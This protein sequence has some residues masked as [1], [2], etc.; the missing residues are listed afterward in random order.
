MPLRFVWLLLAVSLPLL[1]GAARATAADAPAALVHPIYGQIPDAPDHD[2]T[3]RVFT[4]AAARYH[5]GPVEVIDVLAPP[6]SHASDVIKTAARQT[7]KL[8]FADARKE[9]DAVA[10]EV[11]RTGGASL[12]TTELFDLYL[13]RAMATARADWKAPGGP[14]PPGAADE[15]RALAYQDY[16]RAATLTPDRALNPRE[17][18]PQV[19]DDFRRAADEVRAR[20]RGALVVRG[21]ADAQVS[22]DGAA[23]APVAGGVTFR[24]LPYGEHL[25][26][27]QEIGRAPWGTALTLS[28]PSLDLDIP[29]R[30]ALA[31]DDATAARHAL[32]MGAK[33]ALLAQP[34]PGPGAEIDLRLIDITGVRHDAVLVSAV[35]EHGIVDAGVM[36]LDEAARRIYEMGLAP[37]GVPAPP[38]LAEAPPPAPPVL[39]AAPPPRASFNDDPAAWARDHWPL[40][41]AAGVLVASVLI[42]SV[43]VASDR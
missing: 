4:E 7:L 41:T 32:R 19:M 5:L 21:P 8:G 20:P 31:I 28:A 12:P 9:L 13:Y 16:L 40:L 24:D 35:G 39:L 6:A 3:R 17:L 2:V 22:L 30:E 36:R 34:R 38:A 37:G 33:F 26:H 29:E 27:L 43:T 11:A 10:A 25:V 18:P 15:A 1:L 23:P 14:P 42:L